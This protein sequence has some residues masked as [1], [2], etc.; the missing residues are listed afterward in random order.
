MIWMPLTFSSIQ[1]CPERQLSHDANGYR[2]LLRLWVLNRYQYSH[3]RICG[4][5]QYHCIIKYQVTGKSDIGELIELDLNRGVSPFGPIRRQDTKIGGCHL[6]FFPITFVQGR[7]LNSESSW[8]YDH[9]WMQ[10][11]PETASHNLGDSTHWYSFIES[12]SMGELHTSNWSI[13]SPLC[14]FEIIISDVGN[15]KIV[16][17]KG[18][19]PFLLEGR[20]GH[21]RKFFSS[22]GLII[23]LG[24]NPVSLSP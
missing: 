23:M 4:Q 10:P 22:S 24:N 2:W 8:K 9:I 5:W 1:L 12:S 16:G 14:F 17:K 21:S 6:A 18:I 20:K 11:S 13:F 7:G 15:P 3:L 19:L